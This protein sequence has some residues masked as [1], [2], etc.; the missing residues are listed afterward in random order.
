MNDDIDKLQGTWNVVALEIEGQPMPGG[1][2]NG[3]KIVVSGNHFTSMAMGAVYEGTVRVDCG[4]TPKTLDMTFTVG[5]EAGNTSYGIYELGEDSWRLCLTLH[6]DRRP[7]AFATSPGS[8][9]ALETLLREGVAEEASGEGKAEELLDFAAA[10]E[11]EGEWSMIACSRDGNALDEAFMKQAKR[12][13]T[14]NQTTVTMGGMVFL[15]A[16]FTVDRSRDPQAIDYILMGGPSEGKVQ[17]GIY[18]LE[19]DRLT[20]AFSMPGRDRPTEFVSVKGDG[21]TVTVWQRNS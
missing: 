16:L 1:V 15:Q 8:G 20:M 18:K 17:Y 12:T 9:L 14:G 21:R 2:I 11:L 19:G 6:G 5:P 13:A 10:P 7:S 4:L 3:S